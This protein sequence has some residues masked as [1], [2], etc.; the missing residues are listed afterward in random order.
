MG[1]DTSRNKKRNS[2]RIAFILPLLIDE[3]YRAL[4]HD[5]QKVV[6]IA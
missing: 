1:V 2:K 3:K 4:T 5:H 6:E